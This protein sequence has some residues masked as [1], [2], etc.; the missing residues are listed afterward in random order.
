MSDIGSMNIPFEE[1]LGQEVTG[2]EGYYTR[3]VNVH[4]HGEGEVQ[5]LVWRL[6]CPIEDLYGVFLRDDEGQEHLV[7]IFDMGEN[8][9]EDAEERDQA[10]F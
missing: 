6:G 5:T 2:A 8:A 1:F 9:D 10:A 3:V 7:A 4:P